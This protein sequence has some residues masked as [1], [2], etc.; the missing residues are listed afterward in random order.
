MNGAEEQFEI[1]PGEK[2]GCMAFSGFSIAIPDLSNEM[3][4]SLTSDCWISQRL[5]FKVDDWWKQQLGKII[6]DRLERYSSFVLTVKLP[7]SQPE[8]VDADNAF[9]SDRLNFLLWGIAVLAGVPEFES[10]RLLSGGRTPTNINLRQVGSVEQ[11][12]RTRAAPVPTATINDLGEA[13]RFAVR[14]EAVKREKSEDV[15]LYWRLTSGLNAFVTGLK[16]RHPDARLHQFVRAV[17]SFLPPSVFGKNKFSEHAGL[18]LPTGSQ[19]ETVLQQMYDLRSAAEHHRRFDTRTLIGVANPETVAMQRTRQA[20]A[21]ARELYRRFMT[22]KDDLS[23]SF[24]NDDS[25][26]NLWSKS[27]ELNRI[28]GSPFN[29]HA[30]T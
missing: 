19:T 11:F 14:I 7:S 27:D 20:E 22:G 28:W 4:S 23:A 18:L 5:P 10:G 29:I 25:I 9:L 17:E 6:A 8:I 24:K 13:A 15:S 2:F 1:Q 30:I 26:E 12:Y 21:F 16:A 3:L